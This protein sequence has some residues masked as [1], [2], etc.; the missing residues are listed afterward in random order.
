[1]RR[2]KQMNEPVARL[3]WRLDSQAAQQLELVDRFALQEGL[4]YQV[5]RSP[6]KP[7]LAF[8]IPSEPL[9]HTSP[10]WPSALNG[11]YQP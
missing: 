4:L 11:P 10:E 6:R 9:A 2:L 1:M 5:F 3:L 7:S 8:D